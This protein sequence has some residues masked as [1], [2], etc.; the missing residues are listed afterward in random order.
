MRTMRAD[1][2]CQ[3]CPKWNWSYDLR[4]P[5]SYMCDGNGIY[6]QLKVKQRYICASIIVFTLE[7]RQ[8]FID[9]DLNLLCGFSTDAIESFI[10]RLNDDD[11]CLILFLNN[12]LLCG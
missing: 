12:E 1:Y 10:S 4:A 8:T 7:S 6:A 9:I 3:V 5:V 2:K 11:G